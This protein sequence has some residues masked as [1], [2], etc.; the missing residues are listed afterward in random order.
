MPNDM[1]KL[2]KGSTGNDVVA[3]GSEAHYPWGTSL[4][5]ED[6]MIEKLGVDALAAGDIVEVRGYAIVE[7][8]N[9]SSRADGDNSKSMS[10]QFTELKVDRESPDRV[11]TLYGR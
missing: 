2:T 6:D 8:K 9:E 3:C 1:I 11:E 10:L 5:L 7:Y 4:S